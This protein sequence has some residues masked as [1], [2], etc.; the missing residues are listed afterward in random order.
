[1]FERK[2]SAINMFL[3]FDTVTA[4]ICLF[5]SSIAT[6]SQIYSDPTLSIV[7]STI[8]SENF[9]LFDAI[10]LGWYF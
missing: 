2:R 1:M 9:L 3:S 10:L 5:V 7:S 6:Q 8:Y 4:R